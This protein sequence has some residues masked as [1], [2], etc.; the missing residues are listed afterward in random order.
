MK[1]LRVALVVPDVGHEGG[2]AAMA[3]F[4]IQAIQRSRRYEY[5][6]IS[7]ATS[8]RDSASPRILSPR[9]LVR[10]P[11]YS[12]GAWNGHPYKHFG[13]WLPE[14]E[15]QRYR[16]RARLTEHLRRYDLV[17]VI[18]GTPAWGNVCADVDRPVLL[19]IATLA[20]SERQSLVERAPPL[21]GVW[22]R[23]MLRCTSHLD[24]TALLRAEHILVI[25]RWMLD[26][27]RALRGSQCVDMLPP[28][29]D[30]TLFSPSPRSPRGPILS[31]GRFSDPRKNVRLLFEAYARLRRMLADAPPLVL[32]GATMPSTD[33]LALAEAL[34]IA[35]HL[36][37]MPRVVLGDLVELYRTASCF[38]L[39]SNEEGLGIVVLEAMACGLPVVSTASGGPEDIVRDGVDG[40]LVPVGDAAAMARSLYRVLEDEVVAARMGTAG[41]QRIVDELSL[42]VVQPKVEACYDRLSSAAS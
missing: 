33:D 42:A 23:T 10:A 7:V 38:A 14:F 9:S 21:Q 35:P 30:T 37:L 26:H 5:D 15:F 12:E 13:A 8:S 2:I 19:H 39:S 41:R 29:I 24:R 11:G 22:R 34:G 32:A 17:H 6:L 4:V 1:R 20:N 40:F 28:G 31:V 36:R 25:N 3:S 18:C 27:V 16:P